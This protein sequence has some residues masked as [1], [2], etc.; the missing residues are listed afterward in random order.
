MSRLV[1]FCFVEKKKVYIKITE[2][3]CQIFVR[4]CVIYVPQHCNTFSVYTC[5]RKIGYSE[6]RNRLTRN[7]RGVVVCV[8]VIYNSKYVFGSSSFSLCQLLCTSRARG[9]GKKNVNSNP[10]TNVMTELEILLLRI[11]MCHLP[12]VICLHRN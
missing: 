8:K 9:T 5:G 6:E 4:L 7:Q 11:L 10:S 12:N 2:E 3:P 1:L